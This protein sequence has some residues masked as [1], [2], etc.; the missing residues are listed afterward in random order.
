MATTSSL[1]GRDLG[2]VLVEFHYEYQGRDGVLVSIKPNE[3]YVL[4][5]KTNDHWWQ[6]Q[7]DRTSKPFYIPAKYV[8]ELPT[9]FPSP[10]DF[11]PPSPE[12]VLL[13]MAVPVPVPV[14]IPKT[15]EDPRT[16]P[17]DEVMIRLRPEASKG[18]RKTENRMSTFGVP[19]DFP[20]PS[21]S[22]APAP[23]HPSNPPAGPAESG[24]TNMADVAVSKKHL[25]GFPEDLRDSD[26]HRVPSFSPADPVSTPR[27]QTQPIP[28]E[29]PV[30]PVV[31]V[32]P[33]HKDHQSSS[34]EEELE[35][36]LEE[37]SSGEEDPVK[38]DSNHIYESI[39]DLNLDLDALVRG[40]GIPRAPSEPAPAP[41]PLQD[42]GSLDPKS[43][44]YANVSSV[45][46]T[47][48][49]QIS[50]SGPALPSSPPPGPAPSVP[51]HSPSTSISSSGMISPASPLS[52]QDDWQVHMDQD[53]GKQFY[54]HP[55]TRQTTWSDPRSSPP[56]PDGDLDQSTGGEGG[57][58]TS[59]SPLL[60]PASSQGSAGWDQLMDEA[61]GRFYYHN[62]TS[63]ATTWSAPEP[64]SGATTWSA[65]EPLSPSSPP[66]STANRR[67]DDGPPPLPEEDYPS[68]QNPLQHMC[69]IP[70]A[71][72]DLKDENGSPIKLQELA[73]LPQKL[74]GNGVSE[75]G[76]TV[77][78]KN[79]RHSVAEE[80][81]A[82]GHRRNVSEY[83]E[84][85][86]RRPS[87]DSPQL[88][89]R[90]KLKRNLS[91]RS[92]GSNQLHGHLL[93]KAGIMNKTKVVDHGKKI[94]KNW[95]QSWT[96]LHGGILTF[97]RDPKSAPT[98][99]ASK[100]SQ[101]VP[102]YTVELRGASVD[103]A[104]KDKSSKK[105]VL[106]LKTRQ[107]CE[108]LMQY[109][110]ESIIGDWL[111]VMQDTIRQLE[112][113]HV[114][115]DED[116]AASDKEDKD[117]KRTTTRSSSGSSGSSDSEQRR[118][119]T[120]LRR[121]LQRR[122][123]LQSV[124]ERGYIRDNVFGCHLDT[125]CHRENN[126][127]PRFMEKCIRTVERRGLDVDGIYRVSGNLAVIQKL[128]H[129]A[130][131][132]DQLDLEDGQWEEIHVITGALKLF[133]RE[134][135]EPLFPFSCF[136]KFIAAIQVQDYSLKVSYM[137]DLVC[138]LPLPNHD[139]MELLF[140]HLRRVIENKESNRMSVQSVAIVFGP[141]LLRPQTESANMTIHM[142]FQSQIV[143]LMLNEFHTVFSQR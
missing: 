124:K 79:W 122:P 133:L 121:F 126:T 123:T 8:K 62:P 48:I 33:P 105:N 112:Q 46:K 32:V 22:V 100:T 108:Y 31:P 110:T 59:P 14:P 17:A 78:V 53:S 64:T 101:I 3:R 13:P 113:D 136:D 81:F 127:T 63:G 98:G 83:I 95:S 114:S 138:S 128:R 96:V 57:Q 34:E 97:H 49:P 7:R 103:W 92:S 74:M 19:L 85:S 119:R 130:D 16:K 27:T 71:Q 73:H 40:R 15:L 107:G 52:P 140:K 68:S 117:R 39:Q 41:P 72:L 134:L 65:P 84:V 67:H 1:L 45:K 58:L 4:L 94:R 91:N 44:I 116:E 69:L 47:N 35:E 77:Q 129:K 37:S 10:L 131:H 9:D 70:R 142:V 132:E 118:V 6:V 28:V 5:A 111:K 61:S 56:P 55:V 135:P 141:T 21:S 38:E 82:H 137:K 50:I 2:L 12:P 104:T 66:G 42:V 43:P 25:S 80:T 36:E 86:N 26:K 93:E 30:V 99:T 18:Y 60:S 102:E 20:D 76:T 120:K 24:T 88:S 75:K 115:E 23:R 90:H 106:E 125:L 11:D 139:T 143:E 89:D 51:S 109:D 54:F 29:M 87:P